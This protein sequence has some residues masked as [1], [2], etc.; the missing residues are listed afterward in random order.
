[1]LDWT[2]EDCLASTREGWSLIWLNGEY[3]I[4]SDHTP[5]DNA[6]KYVQARAL[7]GSSLHEKA[8]A[9]YVKS[10]MEKKE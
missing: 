2:H 6:R 10:Q 5:W 9:I 8:W 3:I 7:R 1:M 4:I